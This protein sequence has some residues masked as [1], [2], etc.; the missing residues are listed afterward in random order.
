MDF[1]SKYLSKKD[2]PYFISEIGS[3]VKRA[4]QHD[5]AKNGTC[6]SGE[7]G[8]LCPSTHTE[9]PWTDKAA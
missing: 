2:T 5:G 8:R 9:C 6:I 3:L 7:G 4:F 1:K